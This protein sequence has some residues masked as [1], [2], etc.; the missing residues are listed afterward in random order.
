MGQL[1][2]I[3]PSSFR[4]R[5]NL[6][7]WF[8]L[9]AILPLLVAGYLSYQAI[10]KQAEQASQREIVALARSAG[11]TAMEFMESRSG[12]LLMW[13]KFRLIKEALDLAE[14]R[15]EVCDSLREMVKLSGVYEAITLADARTGRCVAT[16]RQEL[17]DMDFAKD[18]TFVQAKA[19]KLAISS[20][21]HNKMVEQWDKDS[22]GWTLT[23]A[24]PVKVQNE[25]RGV[26]IAYLRWK[27]LET[28]FV[29]T[30]VGKSGYVF[31]MDAND[32]FI[33]HPNRSLYGTATKQLSDQIVEFQEAFRAKRDF[34]RYEWTNTETKRNEA[35]LAGIAY[36]ESGRNLVDLQ[37]KVVASAPAAEVYLLPNILGTLGTI[38][39]LVVV[40]VF[41]LSWVLAG[42]ISQPISAIAAVARQVADRDLTVEAPFFSRT[43]EIGELSVA[44]SSMLESLKLQ[45]KQVWHGADV[46]ETAV[47]QITSGVSEVASGAA[48]VAG[49]VSETATTLEEL[50]RS[51]RISGD[52][53]KSLSETAR[54]ALGAS[55]EGKEATVGTIQGIKGIRD[56]I[57]LVGQTVN[58]LSEQSVSIEQIISTV[59]DLAD[60]SNLLAVNASIEA[61]RAGESGKGFSVV[62]HE[63][64]SL[65][66][67][68]R[69]STLQIGEILQNI[70]NSVRAV[71]VSMQ[72]V[73]EALE[74]GINQSS[75]TEESIAVLNR[76]VEVSSQ[77]AAFIETSS[78]QQ[79][80]GMDQVADAMTS[81]EQAMGQNLS[82]VR[83]LEDA[84]N[85]LVELGRQ[86]TKS[87]EAYRL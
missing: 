10:E 43:D 33:A 61:A 55:I 38:L 16:S 65:A 84:A 15:E 36:P 87:A 64:K 5:S 40:I 74:F 29:G 24:V 7:F 11:K 39:V 70:R 22:G 26:L 81:I 30:K 76:S 4:L 58:K 54:S 17:F 79:N 41:V 25:V 21:H 35:K 19:G 53:A 13:A 59:R 78:S 12:D 73:N 34:L 8:L 68:S 66:D 47:Q 86:I 85:K 75:K 28:L 31:V 67:Q 60:Q 77:E 6:V 49:S 57:E 44:F 52:K 69:Q 1:R 42:R 46:L 3:L 50:R 71:V 51:A 18:D 20:L 37:W 72:Q 32:R 48:Q 2:S 83:E 63:I 9:V 27:A 82:A 45:I 80:M 23:I 56:Q 62:A 14:I